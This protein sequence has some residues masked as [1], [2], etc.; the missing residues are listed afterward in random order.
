MQ[1][2]RAALLRLRKNAYRYKTYRASHT[3]RFSSFWNEMAIFRKRIIEPYAAEGDSD[4][5]DERDETAGE[6]DL[7]DELR[8]PSGEQ[9]PLTMDDFLQPVNH[10]E[11]LFQD[12]LGLLFA[13]KARV[14]MA[15]KNRAMAGR[16]GLEDG[17][18]TPPSEDNEL[19]FK[20]ATIFESDGS[21]DSIKTVNQRNLAMIIE[22][23]KAMGVYSDSKFRQKQDTNTNNPSEMI[24]E[25]DEHHNTVEH[26]GNHHHE[27]RHEH[28]NQARYNGMDTHKRHSM[29]QEEENTTTHPEVDDED[30]NDGYAKDRDHGDGHGNSHQIH[31]GRDAFRSPSSPGSKHRP[32]LMDDSIISHDPDIDD[33]LAS[34]TF[35]TELLQQMQ[36]GVRQPFFDD[37]VDADDVMHAIGMKAAF[38]GAREPRHHAADFIHPATMKSEGKFNNSLKGKWNYDPSITSTR[39]FFVQKTSEQQSP[40]V[41]PLKKGDG[42]KKTNREM[43]NFP[44]QRD[45]YKE[46]VFNADSKSLMLLSKE[47]DIV[48]QYAEV[49]ITSVY[50]TESKFQ[51]MI[52]VRT[53]DLEHVPG[54]YIGSFPLQQWILIEEEMNNSLLQL[55]MNSRNQGEHTQIQSSEERE[56]NNTN[57]HSPQRHAK[58]IVIPRFN[59]KKDDLPFVEPIVNRNK[60]TGNSTVGQYSIPK[61]AIR[62]PISSKERHKM[63]IAN[64]MSK[65]RMNPPGSPLFKPSDSWS[66]A[67]EEGLVGYSS[68][69]EVVEPHRYLDLIPAIQQQFLSAQHPQAAVTSKPMMLAADDEDHSGYMFPSGQNIVDKKQFLDTTNFTLTPQP[70]PF[71]RPITADGQAPI[72]VLPPIMQSTVSY[73]GYNASGFTA[74]NQPVDIVLKGRPLL[75]TTAPMPPTK[76]N[77][78]KSKSFRTQKLSVTFADDQQKASDIPA[79]ISMPSRV[80]TAPQASGGEMMS[81]ELPFS[82][83]LPDV[84]DAYFAQN[85]TTGESVTTTEDGINMN[86]LVEEEEVV[87]LEKRGFSYEFQIVLL[88]E[89]RRLMQVSYCSTKLLVLFD[90]MDFLCYPI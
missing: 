54:G 83:S 84:F 6:A 49:P 76:P 18:K 27:D 28:E 75:P 3:D 67:H 45:H 79:Y 2:K 62:Q 25:E 56:G 29:R 34:P 52:T 16:G 1:H 36:G 9:E 88:I 90:L 8:P 5:M 66:E 37:D 55:Q 58:P 74:C 40:R 59:E 48:L 73:S 22:K 86:D 44:R 61:S 24:V 50:L 71:I 53:T 19:A 70:I 68:L 35:L 38:E 43:Y 80:S 11:S 46:L 32:H 72:P 13:T 82:P 57:A 69:S 7:E 87:K 64:A 30:F 31:H 42:M 41:K 14:T 47:S 26:H 23:M 78:P 39:P 21:A 12:D 63:I 33:I 17:N 89:S 81:D 15:A 60:Y 10:L 77:A 65:I 51:D 4:S 85:P 20:A